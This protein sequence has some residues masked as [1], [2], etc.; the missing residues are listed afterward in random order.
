MMTQALAIAAPSLSDIAAEINQQ[1]DLAR[2]YAGQAF[3]HAAKAGL[4]LIEAKR[5]VPHGKWLAWLKA[6]VKVSARQAQ[7]YMKL[8]SCPEQKRNAVADLSMRKA[9]H[10]RR[11]RGGRGTQHW[12]Q[13]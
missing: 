4:L 11:R 5:H 9:I 3:D 2:V 1:H 8:A 6:N 13:L 12:L 10:D 7:N